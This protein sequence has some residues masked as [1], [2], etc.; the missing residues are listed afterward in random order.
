VFSVTILLDLVPLWLR[1]SPGVLQQLWREKRVLMLA[2]YNVV[3]NADFSTQISQCFVL[4]PTIKD[5]A[6]ECGVSAN[7]VSSVLN[8]KP[9]E[10]S[11]RTRER[12]L[13][14]MRRMDYR[15]SAAA[16]RHGSAAHGRQA[17]EHHRHRRS[18]HGVLP[19]KSL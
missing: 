5:I 10:V 4:M 12:I 15:P 9:G 11:A 18:V 13:G 17:D 16:R 6:R 7:T 2:W 3:A 19:R 8:N 14:A 1:L